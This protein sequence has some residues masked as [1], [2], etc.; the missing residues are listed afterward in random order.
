MAIYTFL[1]YNSLSRFPISDTLSLW[2]IETSRMTRLGQVKPQ[3]YFKVCKGC[4]KYL[5]INPRMVLL[6]MLEVLWNEFRLPH[7]KYFNT[8]LIKGPK[9]LEKK[10]NWSEN[11]E[12]FNETTLKW[13]KHLSGALRDDSIY[14]NLGI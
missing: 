11:F 13:R 3:K 4:L 12:D 1:L 9:F 2:F 7:H 6:N 14:V 10:G 8:Y 5:E